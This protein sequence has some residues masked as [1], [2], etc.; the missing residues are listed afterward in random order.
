MSWLEQFAQT[1]AKKHKVKV[2]RGKSWS[3][4]VEKAIVTYPDRIRYLTPDEQMGMLLHEVAHVKYTDSIK[5]TKKYPLVEAYA[6]LTKSA[7]NMVE[8]LRIDKAIGKEY[9]GAMQALQLVRGVQNEGLLEKVKELSARSENVQ[10][11][12]DRLV[13]GFDSKTKI[14]TEQVLA[15]ASYE[16]T[17]IPFTEEV[18]AIAHLI[19]DGKTMPKSYWNPQAKRIAER[20]AADMTKAKVENLKSTKEVYDFVDK[21]VIQPLLPYVLHSPKEEHARPEDGEVPSYDNGDKDGTRKSPSKGG[22]GHEHDDKKADQYADND[23]ADDAKDEMI[24]KMVEKRT[25]SRPAKDSWRLGRCKVPTYDYARMEFKALIDQLRYQFGRILQDNRAKREEGRYRTGTLNLRRIVAHR[26]GDMRLFTRPTV[27]NDK[28]YAVS[29]VIDVSGSMGSHNKMVFATEA[30][31]IMAEILK[32]VKIPCA[33]HSYSDYAEHIKKINDTQMTGK[34][35]DTGIQRYAGRGTQAI[36]ALRVAL[37]ELASSGAD[38]QIMM[39]MTDGH[40]S[41]EDADICKLWMKKHPAIKVYP[42]GI[43]TKG[44]LAKTF[45]EFEVVELDNVE[46][47]LGAFMGILKQYLRKVQH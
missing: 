28:S 46:A 18:L 47:V 25:G 17:K 37:P 26:T 8:D 20:I 19:H 10:K 14:P 45:P 7:V 5:D 39:L 12:V 21:H 35:F 32:G 11:Y 44:S 38:I 34:K 3:T 1:V 41:T 31:V 36:N 9:V 22:C 33:I 13:A 4:D 15:Q 27:D 43:G 24:D 30:T 6:G 16:K 23:D 40:L 42:I 29:L 2:K